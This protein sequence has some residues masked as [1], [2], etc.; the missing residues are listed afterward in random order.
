MED[1]LENIAV[2]SLHEE[3]ANID[4]AELFQEC[5]VSSKDV[6]KVLPVAYTPAELV[7]DQLKILG[8]D[9]K[10]WEALAA[11]YNGKLYSEDGY[12]WLHWPKDKIDMIDTRLWRKC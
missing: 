9:I 1:P 4:V 12:L 6:A 5:Q 7:Y 10:Y 8:S 2:Y 11:K 3:L